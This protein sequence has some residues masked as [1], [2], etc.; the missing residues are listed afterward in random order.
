M[1][2]AAELQNRMESSIKTTVASQFAEQVSLR[3]MLKPEV[4]RRYTA[5]KTGT[6]FLV[7]PDA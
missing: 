2:R 5:K 7:N 4:I 1:A 6:K 3:D